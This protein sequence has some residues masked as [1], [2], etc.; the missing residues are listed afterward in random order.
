MTEFIDP[1]PNNPIDA[2]RFLSFLDL[3][4]VLTVLEGFYCESWRHRHPPEAMLR[5]VALYKLK[6]FRFLTEL[7]KLLD[8]ET[9]KLLGFRWKPSYKTVWHWLNVRLGPEGLETVHSALMKAMNEALEIQ[10]VSLGLKVAGDA[11]P[12]QAMPRDKEA[13]YNG[14]YKEVCYLVHRLICSTTNLTLSCAVTPGNVD[15]T[16]MMVVLLV[17]ALLLGVFPNETG[18]DNGYASPW[19]YALLGLTTIKPFIG[20]RKNAK[21]NWRGKP[22][23][24]RLRFKKMVKAGVLKADRLKALGLNPDPDENNIEKILSGLTIAGQYEYVGAYY[25][26]LSLDEFRRDKR[27]W[28]KLYV[29]MRN[30]I[31]GSNG[32]QKDWLDLDN[33]R[34]KGLQ[35]ARLHTALSMLSEALFAYTR[36]QNGVLK[37]LTSTA[38]L[39]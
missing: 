9:L 11:S 23:T 27:G 19:S 10:G 29:S 12:I 3:T 24:L 21:S 35:N 1:T 16:Y 22:K 14:Y 34:V 31:E 36:A 37:G 5:L 15:E 20:F 39:K 32:H 18:F 26:N 8:D 38:Y 4:A 7:W 6:R 13:R 17:K 28:I 2:A 33:L 25:R 30:V